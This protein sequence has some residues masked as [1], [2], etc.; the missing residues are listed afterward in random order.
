[1]SSRDICSRRL[2][3]LTGVGE[4]QTTWEYSPLHGGVLLEVWVRGA[5]KLWSPQDKMS[6]SLLQEDSLRRQLG[7]M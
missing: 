6:E 1:M 3:S 2:F 5:G 4:S 7:V